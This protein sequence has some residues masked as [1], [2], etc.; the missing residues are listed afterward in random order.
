MASGNDMR[1]ARETYEGFIS[2]AKWGS[3][4]IAIITAGVVVLI[5]S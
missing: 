1:A 5:A 3:I 4:V 2:K